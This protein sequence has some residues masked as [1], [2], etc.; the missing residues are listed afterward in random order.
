VSLDPGDA[1]KPDSVAFV[2]HA[3]V[4]FHEVDPLGHVN[5]AAYLNYLEQAAI[6]HATA[7]GL[8][9]E[10]LDTLGGFF[11]ARHH[12]IHFLRPA[13]AGDILRVVTWLSEGRG[14]RV[15]RRYLVIRDESLP[16]PATV[17]GQVIAGSEVS[18]DGE[19]VARAA[20]EWV[21]VSRD[22]KPRRV[23]AEIGALFDTP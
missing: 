14:A 1:P 6:D 5:N 23:P 22:G 12:D 18:L 2:T 9:M 3:R 8:D 21:F 16:A 10:R 19:L 17:L 15:T 13:F 20:T 11:V 7:L 4:R